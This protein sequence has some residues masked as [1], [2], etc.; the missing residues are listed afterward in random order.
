MDLGLYLPELKMS[1]RF[2][3]ENRLV[4]VLVLVLVLAVVLV[5]VLVLVLVRGVGEVGE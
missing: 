3:K 2:G 5:L 4:L 1:S